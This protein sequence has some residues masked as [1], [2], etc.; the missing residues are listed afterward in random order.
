MAKRGRKSSAELAVTPL[1]DR[2]RRPAPPDDLTADQKAEWRSVVEAM[3]PDWFGRESHSLLSA[4]CRHTTRA[5][6]L[7]GKID[8]IESDELGKLA[9]MSVESFDRLARAAERETRA[10]LA[11]ARSL[12][13]T[14]QAQADPKT[15]A[16][17]RKNQTRARP[18]WWDGKEGPEE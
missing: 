10:M 16:T 1:G 13:I 17:K 15:A 3:P 14:H 9:G 4:Y 5:R 11:V 6:M 18:P 8:N 7:S 12:R 2:I